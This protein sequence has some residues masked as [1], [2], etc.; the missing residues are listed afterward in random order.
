MKKLL[1]VLFLTVFSQFLVTAQ[2]PYWMRSAGGSAADEGMDISIDA[3]N[4]TYS[5]GYFSGSAT[6]G[7]GVTLNANGATDIFV[8][9]VNDQGVLQWAV[10]AGG[11]GPDRGLAIK[12]DAA[13]NCYVT[14]YYFGTATFGTSVITSVGGSQDIFIAK[15]NT[16]GILQWV[17]SAGGTEGESGNGITVD[18]SGNVFVTGQFSG[19]ALFGAIS[20]TSAIDPT[21]SLPSIDVFTVKLDASSNFLWAKKG[22]A[23]YTDR[24]LDIASDNSGNVYVVG[25]FSDTITFDNVHNNNMNNAISL[26]KYDNSG[27]EQWFRKIGGST[28]NIAYGI[29]VDAAS[30]IYLTGD[31]QGTMIFFGP[32]DVQLTNSYPNK[33]FVA[34]YDNTGT[35]L[36]GKA[37]GSLSEVSSRNIALDDSSNVYIVG[38]FRC[39]FS[40]YADV[41][42]QGTFNSVG[43]K[44]IFVTKYNT[45]GQRKWM[46]QGG[47]QEEDFGAGI[48]VNTFRQPVITGS[49][50]DK[51][52]FPSTNNFSYPNNHYFP[53]QIY[54]AYTGT[55]CSD[56]HYGSYCCINSIG[57]SDILIAKAIDPTRQPYDYYT[58]FS[59][60]CTRPYVDG[61]INNLNYPQYGLDNFCPGDSIEGCG[62]MNLHGATNTSSYSPGTNSPGPYFTWHWSTGSN[63]SYISVT[64]TGN[65]AVTM[66]SQDG[67]YVSR[68]TVYA[69]I[70]PSPAE[71]S[72]SDD[73][74]V[75]TNALYPQPIHLCYPQNVTLTG[76]T[77]VPYFYWTDNNSNLIDSSLSITVNTGGW[78]HFWVVNSLGCKNENSVQVI[79]DSSL[80]PLHPGIMLQNDADHNDSIELCAGN[81]FIVLL[82]DSVLNPNQNLVCI[83]YATTTF[84]VTPAI[85]FFNDCSTW[86]NCFPTHSGS[87]QITAQLI[88]LNSCVSDTFNLSKTIYVTVDSLPVINMVIAGNTLICPGDT[89]LLTASGA[90]SYFWQ[91][92]GIIGNPNHASIS[93]DLPGLY[94]VSCT[95]TDSHGCTGHGNASANVQIKPAPVITMVPSNGI[96]CSNDSALLQCSGAGNFQ[97]YGTGGALGHNT[98]SMYTSLPGIYYCV[99]TD[100]SGCILISNSVEVT[101]FTTPYLISTP[102]SVLCPGSSI[103]IHAITSPVS[104][105]QWQ[106]PLNGSNFNQIVTTAGTYHCHIIL[107]GDTA[108]ASIVITAD[109][110]LAQITPAGP[111]QICPA[112]SVTLT[113]NPGEVAYQWSLPGVISQSVVINHPGTY[114]LTT[115][116]IDGCVATDNFILTNPEANA[117]ADQSICIGQSATLSA[118]GGGSY[119]WNT[120]STTAII[121]V[122]PL[123]TTV[124]SVTVTFPGC[125]ASDS[126]VVTVNPIP[127]AN[128]GADQ[129]I[130]NGQS[131]VLSAT[132]G[133]TYL[134]SNNATTDSITVNPTNTTTYSVVVTTLGCTAADSVVV[135]VNPIP[136]INAGTG[137]S[138]CAGQSDTLTATGGDSY[139]WST[140]DTIASIIVNPDSST[141]YTVTGMNSYGCSSTA[142]VL[143]TVNQLPVINISH[144]PPTI[145]QGN[146]CTITASGGSVYNW[147][148]STGLD[149]TSGSVI[150]ASPMSSTTYFVTVSTHDGCTDTSSVVVNVDSLFVVNLGPD[151]ML[152]PDS[153]IILDAGNPGDSY[154]WSTGEVS[155]AIS[156]ATPGTYWV[157]VTKGACNVS[158][159]IDVSIRPKL[160]LGDD[161]SLCNEAELILNSDLVTSSYLWST[162]QTTP[163]IIVQEPGKYW[164]TVGINNCKM[165]DTINVTGG[166]TNLYVPNAFT[167]NKNGVN[168]VFIP[169]GEGIV[170]FDMKIFDRWGEM[171]FETKDFNKGWDGT[172]KDRIVEQGIYVWII[173]YSTVCTG[174]NDLQKLG[175]VLL[176]K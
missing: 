72:I 129:S 135:N 164:L 88:R 71:P 86:I 65:Y 168:D 152:C 53:N 161:V 27:T 70:D 140:G 46:R 150:M 81:P 82:F 132:S 156:V 38:N 169:K 4:N 151:L 59:G 165:S 143:L 23:K 10:K 57:N 127:T 61:C 54:P 22:S 130:C 105:V 7:T 69:I 55:Y 141:V 94:Q 76:N 36:W 125:S 35:F 113:A 163:A 67:C 91:G 19:T 74:V 49:F 102:S 42:G 92:P 107:C 51:V 116:D 171:L 162:G 37:D 142:K 153:S 176:F 14:G 15:Y 6:F 40:D 167:P 146:S 52:F 75:N 43:F 160:Q 131:A 118:T 111:L 33:I 120:D 96:I 106:P 166:Y 121:T 90:P 89:A 2:S 18:N 78:Y 17:V 73:F 30:N 126:I 159:S 64:S 63:N 20:L 155:H 1:F 47:G 79:V 41:F 123:M 148:P 157:N 24:G 134:W 170:N 39:T 32:P 154:L 109:N 103:T 26:I 9:K 117:G 3:N 124:Y 60:N 34:K 144:I 101:N 174:D 97:W 112:D 98:S 93:A 68:D 25:Q 87:Y 158:D 29:A 114:T 128:A 13:G 84:T 28:M 5:T 115:T 48:A 122:D 8:T 44:D 100:T 138:I 62:F 119:L 11:I 16:S 56:N 149:T 137:Q 110:P 99:L 31:F 77:T 66:T 139:L 133:G 58:R 45:N 147:S 83:N 104:I 50:N 80:T 136:T 173:K 12:A 21:T 95:I 108:D 172:F 85:L 145:C 175:H